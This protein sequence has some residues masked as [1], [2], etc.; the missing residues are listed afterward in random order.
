MDDSKEE[1]LGESSKQ[2]YNSTTE[3]SFSKKTGSEPHRVDGFKPI[4]CERYHENQKQVEDDLKFLA[5]T[6]LSS[7]ATDAKV[8]PTSII[9]VDERARYKCMYPPCKWYGSSVIC[10]PRLELTPEKTRQIVQKY[11]YAVLIKIE[12]PVNALA[13]DRWVELHV[14]FEW[15]VKEIVSK[16]MGAAF[17]I[18]YHLN[19]G[20]AAGECTPCLSKG[21]ECQ[22]L[23]GQCRFP[24]MAIPAMEAAGIDV[25]S[26]VRNAGW[27][28]YPIGAS[29][30]LCNIPCAALYGL[31]LVV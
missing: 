11:K 22:A 3:N 24:F 20:F 15:K 17:N 31:V 10:P 25:F 2:N 27:E 5:D 29:T 19:L 30:R 6:A 21:L 12:A 7:G 18:G 14:P 16:V 8:V 23:N 4:V 13:G 26:T 28:I 9:V 1:S